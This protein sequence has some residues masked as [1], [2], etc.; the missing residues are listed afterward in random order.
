M[1]V[2]TTL[3]QPAYQ[4]IKF[5]EKNDTEA[6]RKELLDTDRMR[7]KYCKLIKDRKEVWEL[8]SDDEW[9]V[10]YCRYVCDRKELWSKLKN[11]GWVHVYLSDIEDRQEL[12]DILRAHGVAAWANMSAKQRGDG[13]MVALAEMMFSDS[14]SFIR[15][16]K[17][18]S[19]AEHRKAVL[20]TDKLRYFY[21]R[22]VEDLENVWSEIT[23]DRWLYAY[24]VTIKDRSSVN[25]KITSEQWSRRHDNWVYQGRHICE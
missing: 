8:I 21:C 19:T 18:N 15:F 1:G 24:C 25:G 7:Y 11:V 3:I 2:L 22:W 9:I 17:K 13:P 16:F 5:L 10:E 23:E 14:K 12:R 6:Y 4:R 20:T